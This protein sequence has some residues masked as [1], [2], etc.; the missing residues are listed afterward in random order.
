MLLPITG[1]KWHFIRSYELVI[2]TSIACYHGNYLI[3]FA[4]SARVFSFRI[5]R[6]DLV[7][8]GTQSNI[9]ELHHARF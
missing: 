9:Q 7:L 2:I 4:A 1:N 6:D 5:Q 8:D 3:A